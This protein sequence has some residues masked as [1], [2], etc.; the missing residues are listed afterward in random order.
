MMKPS[1]KF[2]LLTLTQNHVCDDSNLEDELGG[3]E[4]ES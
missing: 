2:W 1:V 3:G 4:G